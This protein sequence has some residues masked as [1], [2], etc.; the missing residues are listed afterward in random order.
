MRR[1]Q[2]TGLMVA[3]QLIIQVSGLRPAAATDP[4]PFPM[5]RRLPEAPA[6]SVITRISPR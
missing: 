2:T 4:V 1:D 6:A 3:K 5:A